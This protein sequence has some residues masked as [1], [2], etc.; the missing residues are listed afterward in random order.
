MSG[1]ASSS[2]LPR[3]QPVDP[4]RRTSHL[5]PRAWLAMV[6]AAAL[7][8]G[9][10]QPAPSGSPMPSS[11]PTAAPTSATPS[12]STDTALAAAL[13]SAI[14]IDD[15]LAGLA[16]LQDIADANGG[17]RVAG[18]PGYDASAAYVA[19]ELRA[20]G[21]TVTMDPVEFP[22]FHQVSPATL[23]LVG[24]PEFA[25]P[26]DVKAMVFSAAGDVTGPLYELGFDP[27]ADPT[28]RNGKGCSGSDWAGVPRGVIAV[29]QPGPCRRYDVVQNAAVAGVL[30]L[31]TSYPEWAPGQVRRPTLI[32]PADIH[33]PVLGATHDAGVALATAAAAGRSARV[34]TTTSTET[35]TSMNVIGELA[36]SDPSRIL[37]LGGH[38][39]SV[40]DGPGIN[41]NGTGTMTVL[42]MARE[43]A[44][45]RAADP[46]A[47]RST[48]RVAFWTGEEE[49][50]YGSFS[51]AA[52][53]DPIEAGRIAAY[54]N[55][56][57]LGSPN[58]V[59]VI[60]ATDSLGRP[61]E[62]EAISG[63]FRNELE[64]GGFAW[65]P[66]VVGPQSDHYP[67]EQALV[68]VGGLFSG[69]NEPKTAA[70]AVLFGGTGDAPRDPCYHL[71]CDTE[72][73]IDPVLLEQL[74][75]AAAWV[76]GVL[77]SGGG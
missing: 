72:D 65:L 8:A 74:A 2:T 63:L 22:Y 14:E 31:V 66:E 60:Y 48:V 50:L 27:N 5:N 67:F 52:K 25:D 43:L 13:R 34:V 29:V 69:A 17:T 44:A 46:A 7:L 40:L 71:A 16:H 12:A 32:D 28:V 6:L 77:I 38:L 3:H 54:L 18:S 10:Q 41:D 76:A 61:Q 33:M 26:R 42:E 51:Y 9:C 73:N 70:E 1:E 35:A 64:S 19:E 37:M 39:D 57:M 21:F 75:R 59:R 45:M 36:G 23:T 49:G 15:I 55:F 4:P 30:A 53:L 68:P 62:D 24:G 56:D 11:A 47:V 20:A 58:G